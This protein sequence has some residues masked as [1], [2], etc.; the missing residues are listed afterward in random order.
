MGVHEASVTPEPTSASPPEA[1]TGGAPLPP[2]PETTRLSK[3]TRA[4]TLV[5]AQPIRPICDP[6]AG[7]WPVSSLNGFPLTKNLALFPTVVTR[8]SLT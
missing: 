7:G 2:G 8:N 3:P 6:P 1:I 4:D 5:G